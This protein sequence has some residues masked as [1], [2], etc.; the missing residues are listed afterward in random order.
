MGWFGKVVGGIKNAYDYGK[1]TA[2]SVASTVGK[3]AGHVGDFVRNP[4]IKKIKDG[5][6]MGL[7]AYSWSPLPGANYAGKASRAL[8]RLDPWL[9]KT[10]KYADK[11]KMAADKTKTIAD[12]PLNALM[13][14]AK[15]K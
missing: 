2:S 7:D 11:V 8:D 14:Q 5:V 13:K 9:E 3:A 12:D 4:I 15:N 10:G 6:K 1:K